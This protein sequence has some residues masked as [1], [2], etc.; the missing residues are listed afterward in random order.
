M[1]FLELPLEQLDVEDGD[2]ITQ[3]EETLVNE[4]ASWKVFHIKLNEVVV[5]A[6][7]TPNAAHCHQVV[8]QSLLLAHRSP[9]L[10]HVCVRRPYMRLIG[11]FLS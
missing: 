5:E 3:S 8:P 9:A 7:D 10:T 1:N 2:D 11:L 6:A 4:D